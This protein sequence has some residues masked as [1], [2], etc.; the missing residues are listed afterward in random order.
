MHKRT[1]IIATIGPATK[2]LE[3]IH[4]L[5]KNGMNVVRVNMSHAS[6]QD[7][8]DISQIV[9]KLNK[10]LKSSI[11][12]MI[13]TQG[14][15]IRTSNFKGSIDL[16][17]GD[18]VT[19]CSTIKNKSAKE[20]RVDNLSYV[21]GL[22]VGGKISLD[23]GQI[24]LKIKKIAKER[25]DCS[26]LDAGI[27][28]GKKH[29]NFPGA[30]VKLPTLTSKDKRDIK[31]GLKCGIDFIA[32][33]FARTDKDLK[34]LTSLLKRAKNKPEIF[35]KIEEQQG[36]DNIDEITRHSDGLL[37]ARGDLGIETDITNLPYV[38][39]KMVRVA[40]QAGKKCIVATQLL[41]SMITNP[42]P[43]RAE[44]S[45]VANAVYEGVDALMLSAETTVGEFPVKCVKYLSDIA[46]NAERSETLHFENNIKHMSDWHTLASTSVKLAKRINADA[47][48]VL[49]RSGFTAN[50][51]SSAR[52]RV[53]VYAFTND[54]TTQNKLSM[55]SS[56]ENIYLNF[57]R[58]HEKTIG[59]AF[60]ILKN[61]FKL[62][63]KKKFIVISGVFSDEYADA[64]QIRF[65][66]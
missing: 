58:D 2:S 34:E 26:V 24:D 23:N 28:A 49:T 37:V 18:V 51:I 53:P 15:E 42:H 38:Q 43:T 40:L 7:L 14:P 33:S 47:I 10:K 6:I 22:K 62:R 29:V 50:L 12:L 41:E 64:I 44:V 17:K 66:K 21:K 20:I 59:D 16:I 56:L 63:G 36:M 61:D 30:T 5:Y 45:D 55:A 35:A 4:K 54:K 8:N 11:G 57:K 46:K 25:I 39:R 60:N 9:T 13:D 3:V 19:L 32:L 65:L 48:V 27:I 31:E 52:P 1:K